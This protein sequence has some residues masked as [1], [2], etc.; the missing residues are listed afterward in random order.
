MFAS[1]ALAFVVSQSALKIED[2]KP[3]TGEGV[4]P[5]DVIETMYT[6]TLLSGKEFD[7]NVKSGKSFRVQIGVGRV[8]KGWD[9]G[10]IGMK[11]DGERNLT[12]PPD[13]GYGDRGSGERIPAG[14]TLKFNVKLVRILPSAK[15]TI[16][17]EGKG[18]SI[19]LGQFLECKLSVKP[20]NGKEMADPTKDS[21]LQLSPQMLPWIN[22]AIAGIKAG[23]KRTVV[24]N[25]ELAFGEKGYPPADV[26]GQKA[27]SQVPP[28]SDLT[29]QIE[30]LKIID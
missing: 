14:A 29:L 3:G 9:Q 23:E 27:G 26:E 22:Q 21:R 17:T 28:K 6:G 19:K 13:L 5:Y 4:K 12:I 25:Y 15:I 1:I 24:I 20:S 11:T 18:D 16:G 2:I 10:F 8:I 30:A 7:S